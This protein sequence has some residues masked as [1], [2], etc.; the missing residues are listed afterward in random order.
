MALSDENMPTGAV[1]KKV[2]ACDR[3]LIDLVNVV[4]PMPFRPTTQMIL[5]SA[6]SSSRES[7]FMACTLWMSIRNRTLLGRPMKKTVDYGHSEF[8]L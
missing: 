4:L 7:R 8:S 1:C 3:F 2:S 6:R 5:F